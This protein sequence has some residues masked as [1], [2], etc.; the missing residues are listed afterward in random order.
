[1]KILFFSPAPT[2]KNPN[3][4]SFIASRV[5]EL[6]KKGIEIE[7]LQFGNL[8][9]QGRPLQTKRKGIIGII[10]QLRNILKFYFIP[11]KIIKHQF[12][13][14]QGSYFYY[15][16]L[17]FMTC[18]QF[19]KW[20]KKNK[21]DFIHG[22]FL[23]FAEQLPM[24]KEK[25]NIPYIITCHGSD[26]HETPFVDPEKASAFSNIL[27]SAKKVIFV[28]DFLR[29]KAEEFGY[30]SK[31]YTIISNGFNPSVFFPCKK[32]PKN[33]IIGFVGHTIHIKRCEILPE[34]LSIVQQTLPDVTLTIIGSANSDEDLRP[35]MKK[36]ASE[37]GVLSSISFVDNVLPE[38][39]GTYMRKFSV[40]AFPS[41]NE[42]FGCVVIEAQACGVPT[43][44]ASN[45]GIPEAI[46]DVGIIVPESESF[47]QD[48]ANAIIM[49][50]KK[51]IEKNLLLSRSN[52]YKWE[53]IIE[54]EID[55]YKEIHEN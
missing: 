31:N 13:N 20:Y 29:K 54:K 22:H 38:N 36:K 50:L 24:L 51:P 33:R 2:I 30:K 53:K 47:I 17:N 9:I 21:F 3:M 5:Y 27:N 25:F 26:V 7:I 28:S 42:G 43:V 32:L 12:E 55:V 18:N 6:K 4:C 35:Y 49:I 46:G 39:V 44:G 8:C 10:A 52:D 23:W 19:V 37:L 34:V 15:D 45:G 1:M 48:F 40:L 16:S 41:K 11:Q 14:K